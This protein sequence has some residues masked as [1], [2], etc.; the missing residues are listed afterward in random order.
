[1]RRTTRA[2]TLVEILLGAVIVGCA[3]VPL[4]TLTQSETHQ[5]AFNEY[6]LMGRLRARR[7]AEA[8]A[9]HGYERLVAMG[10]NAGGGAALLPIPL[11]PPAEELDSFAGTAPDLAYLRTF[12][13]KI[14][15]FNETAAFEPIEPGLAAINVVVTW[16]LPGESS[17]VTPHEARVFKLVSRRDASFCHRHPLVGGAS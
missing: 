1:M 17:S 7:V 5:A 13:A 15:V 16:R 6:Q 11:P 4:L 2:V 10:A 14:A 3:F 9:T 8:L 12:A